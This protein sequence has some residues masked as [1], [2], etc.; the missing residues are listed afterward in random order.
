MADLDGRARRAPTG[1]IRLRKSPGEHR[2]SPPFAVPNGSYQPSGLWEKREPGGNIGKAAT[3]RANHLGRRTEIPGT[4][5]SLPYAF[6]VTSTG[7]YPHDVLAS[8]W[9]RG[10]RPTS[11][12]LA[13]EVGLV[14]ED[15]TSGFCGSDMFK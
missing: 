12:D 2:R 1:Q 11:T 8:G 15:A 5:A 13:L 7:R 3:R 14:L 9:Q 4:R 10:S 6:G